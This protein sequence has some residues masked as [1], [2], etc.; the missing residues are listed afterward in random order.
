MIRKRSYNKDL[1]YL[2]CK[3]EAVATATAVATYSKL[4]LNRVCVVR[5]DNHGNHLEVVFLQE[6][7]C[8][9]TALQG[10]FDF[11]HGGTC[12]RCVA[13]G[14]RLIPSDLCTVCEAPLQKVGGFWLCSTLE[15]SEVGKEIAEVRE[16]HL[17]QEPQGVGSVEG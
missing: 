17:A 12:F 6:R 11:T 10:T 16:S 15:C 14:Q 4:Q 13:C 2:Q 7:H 1:P 8:K 9:H 5:G 3:T